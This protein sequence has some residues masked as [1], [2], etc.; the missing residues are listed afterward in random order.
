MDAGIHGLAVAGVHAAHAAHAARADAARA[1]AVAVEQPWRSGFAAGGHAAWASADGK[2]PSKPLLS[3]AQADGLFDS[4]DLNRDGVISREEF[5]RCLRHGGPRLADLA[6][7]EGSGTSRADA[8]PTFGPGPW[9]EPLAAGSSSC[10]GPQHAEGSAAG[11]R[12]EMLSPSRARAAPPR[13]S[14]AWT[15]FSPTVFGEQWKGATMASS[16]SGPPPGSGVGPLL[17]K[18]CSGANGGVKSSLP[19]S[20]LP[21]RDAGASKE[22]LQSRFS[23]EYDEVT[24][25]REVD[26]LLR[27][28]AELQAQLRDGGKVRPVAS[29][30]DPPAVWLE[31]RQRLRAKIGE[32]VERKSR[33]EVEALRRHAEVVVA[34]R[35]GVMQDEVEVLERERDQ[36]INRLRAEE[37]ARLEAARSADEVE[38]RL[39]KA[40][41]EAD[42]VAWR[43][44]GYRQEEQWDFARYQAEAK[45]LQER[46]SQ[47]ESLRR[48]RSERLRSSESRAERA[49]AA[50]SGLRRDH[51]AMSGRHEALRAQVAAEEEALRTASREHRDAQEALSTARRQLATGESELRAATTR[52]EERLEGLA[53]E[54]EVAQAQLRVA[55]LAAE[56]AA[57]EALEKKGQLEALQRSKS[58]QADEA[59]HRAE[60]QR[61][62]ARELDMSVKDLELRA[63]RLSAELAS[64]QREV[65]ELQV[66]SSASALQFQSSQNLLMSE[67]SRASELEEQG[68]AVLADLRS[69]AQ[70]LVGQLDHERARGEELAS[71]SIGVDQYQDPR[72]AR[73]WD[74]SPEL[75][76]GQEVSPGL[77]RGSQERKGWTRTRQRL[78]KE[79]KELRTWKKEATGSVQRAREGLWLAKSGCERQMQYGKELEA[80][81]AQL[82]RRAEAVSPYAPEFFASSMGSTAPAA[83]SGRRSSSLGPAFPATA[84]PREAFCG[85]DMGAGGSCPDP[86]FPGSVCHGRDSGH[87]GR[88]VAAQSFGDRR[89]GSAD[90][91]GFRGDGLRNSLGGGFG[92]EGQD[93]QC[94]GSRIAH[95]VA[96]PDGHW[97]GGGGGPDA[98]EAGLEPLSGARARARVGPGNGAEV[99]RGAS[100]HSRHSP[101]LDGLGDYLGGASGGNRVNLHG[102][103]AEG[104]GNVEDPELESDLDAERRLL[105]PATDGVFYDDPALA[106]P[107]KES[108]QAQL[109]RGRRRPLRSRSSPTGAHAGRPLQRRPLPARGRVRAKLLA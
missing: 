64:A 10:T 24:L 67:R 61:Q 79:L 62:I 77:R 14:A 96:L 68:R 101:K 65:E 36:L 106:F 4:I 53:H 20:P 56:R 42:G 1:A 90:E 58:E 44:D 66:R 17:P 74:S 25:R 49:R 54:V 99:G 28:N 102:F 84:E 98:R 31:E 3:D 11:L 47:V 95:G 9:S 13:Y 83:A 5:S 72:A 92:I 55:E 48:E 34:Q 2:G 109:P 86:G 80:A 15:G 38:S 108:R 35:S 73:H 12:S 37:Q 33:Q 51:E 88:N 39:A 82:G 26:E 29:T 30:A 21:R 76:A 94:S 70:A 75:S 93:G 32:L 59:Q 104:L 50:L 105:W 23:R 43:G 69:R 87:R 71:E 19:H 57:S 45:S 16:S 81:I 103:Q 40:R 27:T 63:S 6:A 89:A 52:L 100:R 78:Q 8:T 85:Q 97:G 18:S 7:P 91:L 46:L 22:S 107:A 60:A 41:E